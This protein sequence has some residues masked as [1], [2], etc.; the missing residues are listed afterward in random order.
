MLAY[1]D[2][3][4]QGYEIRSLYR[5]IS[6][7]FKKYIVFHN[8]VNP[9]EWKRTKG[10]GVDLILKVGK[11]TIY[12]EEAFCSRDYTYRTSWFIKEKLSRFKLIKESKY[13]YRIILSNRPW[14]FNVVKELAKFLGIVIYHYTQLVIFLRRLIKRKDTDKQEV[15]SPNKEERSILYKVLFNNNVYIKRLLNNNVY[16]SLLKS[17]LKSVNYNINGEK[18]RCVKDG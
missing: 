18:G 5:L 7:G 10:H 15:K 14:N 13:S 2:K 12:V 9:E 3:I 8:P 4:G 11:Y 6:D 16:A 17:L 1:K